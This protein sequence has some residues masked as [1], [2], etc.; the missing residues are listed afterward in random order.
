MNFGNTCETGHTFDRK[1]IEGDM[2]M[3]IYKTKAISYTIE[4][5]IRQE[6]R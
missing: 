4:V 2:Y 6:Q 3:Y 1:L 5:C